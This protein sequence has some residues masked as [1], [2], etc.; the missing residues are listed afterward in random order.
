MVA[1]PLVFE[2]DIWATLADADV[3]IVGLTAVG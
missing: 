2:R 3:F 1:A